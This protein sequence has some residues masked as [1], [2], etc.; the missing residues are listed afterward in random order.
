MKATYKPRK[1][2]AAGGRKSERAAGAGGWRWA[3]PHGL[4]VHPAFRRLIPLQ[5]RGEFKSLEQ[6]LKAEGCRDPLLVWKGKNVVLDGHTRRDLC[7]YLKKKVKV[8]EVELPDE[9]AAVD[10]ILELQRQRRN[11]TREAVSY[12]RGSEYNALKQ[13]RGG[14]KRGPKRVGPRV[15]PVSTA[16]RVAEKHG[17][18]EKTVKRDARFAL[19]VD[20]IV[21][22]YGDPEVKRK[23]LGADVKL[24]RVE[25]RALLKIPAEER[26]AAVDKLI[27]DGELPRE[28]KEAAARRP[29]EVAESILARLQT[30]GEAHARSVVQHLA[31]LLGLE[32]AEKGAEQ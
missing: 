5:S 17:V 22:D 6:S 26:K 11:L 9:Q 23:L 7:I 4:E 31:R 18:N 29:K 28:K 3:D 12:L 14:Q 1:A 30:R 16:H 15:P 24:T 21:A 27:E 2:K 8:R 25:A 32:L 13:R 19:S 20:R 10:Y